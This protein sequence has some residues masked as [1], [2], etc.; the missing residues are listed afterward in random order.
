[1][2]IQVHRACWLLLLSFLLT[3]A[4]L[5]AQTTATPEP[6]PAPPQ[7]G[8]MTVDTVPEGFVGG[9][10][11]RFTEVDGRQATLVGGFAGWSMDHRLVIGGGGYWL[12]NGDDDLGMAYGGAVVEWGLL[13]GNRFDVIAGGLVGFGTARLAVTVEDWPM[14]P[15]RPGPAGRYPYHDDPFY[16]GTVRYLVDDGF[17]VAEPEV[18]LTWRASP[19]VSLTGGVSYRA[20]A[21]ADD[22]NS[23]LRG[24]AG[25][26][27]VVFGPGS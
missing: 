12:A 20:V 9:P 2:T 4:P 15:P 5:A 6:Q 21:W 10:E 19:W 18:R 1:M 11:V 25:S 16:S 22:F 8:P 3:A 26:V 13:G 7:V 23:R 27:A 14:G 24:V 17:F